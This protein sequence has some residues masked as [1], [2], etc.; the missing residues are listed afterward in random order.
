MCGVT[1][2][3]RTDFMLNMIIGITGSIGSGKSTVAA[4]LAAHG[5]AVID[6][7]QVGHEILEQDAVICARL[8]SAFGR[9][10]LTGRRIDRKKL[11]M[12]A[13]NDIKKLQ[14]LNAILHPAIIQNIQQ[15][16]VYFKKKNQNNIVID[17]PLLL[18]TRLERLVDKVI[19]VTANDEIVL[20]RL[21]VSKKI[22]PEMFW[23]IKQQ[24]MPLSQKFKYA[25]AVI[26]NN[27]DVK[28]LQTKINALSAKFLSR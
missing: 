8:E 19:V 23:K 25:D 3:I 21:A 27:G 4:G 7:D 18:E 5:F 14:T 28:E 17:A 20:K 16:I 11:G 2:I 10:I 15:E 26:E 13:F 24:Q 6:A 12:L 22:P 1:F 9:G